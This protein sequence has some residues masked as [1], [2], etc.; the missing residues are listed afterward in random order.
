[1]LNSFSTPYSRSYA[2]SK[3]CTL[4]SSLRSSPKYA[5]NARYGH[6]LRYQHGDPFKLPTS[7]TLSWHSMNGLSI[8][9]CFIVYKY[10]DKVCTSISKNKYLV[11]R[12]QYHRKR[13]GVL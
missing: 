4:T 3:F 8:A 5:L 12:T 6:A 2:T 11:K 7:V 9:G 10:P 13:Y 1:M